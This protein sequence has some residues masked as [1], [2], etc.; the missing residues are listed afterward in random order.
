MERGL[1]PSFGEYARVWG[2]SPERIAL[3]TPEAVVLH[4]GPV[5]RGVE[6]AHE[7]ADGLRARILAQVANGVAVRCAVLHRCVEATR[8]APL[9]ES[10]L[11]SAIEARATTSALKA[12]AR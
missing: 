7:V 3:M 10:L 4:P 8:R 2:L 9:P 1:L 11:D 5:N 12:T 6:L